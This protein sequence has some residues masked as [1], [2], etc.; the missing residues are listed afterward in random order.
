MRATMAVNTRILPQEFECLFPK[1]IHEAAHMLTQYGSDA[2]V[3]AGGTDLLVRMKQGLISPGYLILIVKIPE[4]IN[5]TKDECLR[6]GAA[7]R[8]CEVLNFCAADKKYA[9]LG[10]ALRSLGKVQVRNIATIG[11]NLCNASPAADSAPPLLVFDCRIKLCSVEGERILKLEKFFTGV[12]V[13]TMAPHEIMTEI[14]IPS[15]QNGMGSAFTKITRVGADISK[16]SCAV[17]VERRGDLC[18][19]CRIAMG[20]VASIPMRVRAA[21]RIVTGKKVDVS[22]VEKLGRKVSEEIN[23][24]TDI[25]ST[26]EYRRKVTPVLF[27]DVF[28]RAWQRAG[29][30]A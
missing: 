25:R 23:P 4:L 10:E 20:A 11:G 27:K 6:I 12:N 13:T 28:W 16:M 18:A 19:S 24:I 22:V 7:T 2:K 15:I 9:A 8:L 17:A 3:V 14:Q 1:T 30:K 5:I 29:G 21:E 26:A